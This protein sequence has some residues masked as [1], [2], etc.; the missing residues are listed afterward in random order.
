MRAAGDVGVFVDDGLH[1]DEPGSL[2]TGNCA[3]A[4]GCS[5]GAPVPNHC[6]T[7]AGTTRH[8][9]VNVSRIN[10]R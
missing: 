7:L 1:L 8:S 9:K 3:P 6:P 10:L 5:P 2:A 4:A